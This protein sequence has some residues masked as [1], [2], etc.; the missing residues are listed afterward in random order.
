M[1][2]ARLQEQQEE[3]GRLPLPEYIGWASFPFEGDLRVKAIADIELPEPARH[4]AGGVDCGTC[5]RPDSSYVWANADWRVSAGQSP[6]ALP[7]VLILEPRAHHDLGDLPPQLLATLGTMIWRVDQALASLDGVVR[8]QLARWGD[9]AE[10]LHLWFLPRPEGFVQGRGSFLAQWNELL[11][12]QP[13]EEWRATL[14][15]VRRSLAA[16]E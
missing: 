7:A 15:H 4:G 3:N 9:G 10:H 11:P 6:S 5:G 1:D 2:E 8:V 12:A 16:G 14:Q 13:E